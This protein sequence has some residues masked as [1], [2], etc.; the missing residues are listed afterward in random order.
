MLETKNSKAIAKL[1]LE[2]RWLQ[3]YPCPVKAYCIFKKN[4]LYFIYKTGEMDL[5]VV[6]NH[7]LQDEEMVAL[8]VK[9]NF[10]LMKATMLDKCKPHYTFS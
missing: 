5:D 6:L 7:P 9:S 4:P 1:I 3:E 10:A 2:D 8:A